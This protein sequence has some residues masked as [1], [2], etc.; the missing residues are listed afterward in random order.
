MLI[1]LLRLHRNEVTSRPVPGRRLQ[2]GPWEGTQIREGC[3][4]LEAPLCLRLST[5]QTLVSTVTSQNVNLP[6]L[7]RRGKK[8]TWKAP[9]CKN[10][11]EKP[12]MG[13]FL[14]YRKRLFAEN[15]VWEESGFWRGHP[16]SILIPPG[17]GFSGAA[18]TWA[19]EE[20]EAHP[21]FTQ[22]LC[23]QGAHTDC[24]RNLGLRPPPVGLRL[25]LFY[26]FKKRLGGLLLYHL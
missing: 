16:S 21:S 23:S 14:W 19:M 1:A 22:C 3:P 13:I 10:M 20:T 11:I 12:H 2:W 18:S 8:C 17:K 7:Q 9:L 26:I 15:R 24:S 5:W 25:L 4:V 6:I